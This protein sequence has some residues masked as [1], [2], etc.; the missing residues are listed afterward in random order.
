MKKQNATD[1]YV[2]VIAEISA[3][4]DAIKAQ[5]VDNHLG[6]SPDAVNWGNVGTAQHLLVVLAEAAEIAGVLKGGGLNV[7]GKTSVTLTADELFYLKVAVGLNI[8]TVSEFLESGD[9]Y[10]VW[11]RELENLK[12]AYNKI[13]RASRRV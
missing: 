4:L 8:K 11:G 9:S 10:G 2:A 12:T 1:A 7:Y 3:K 5:A 13:E 6:V